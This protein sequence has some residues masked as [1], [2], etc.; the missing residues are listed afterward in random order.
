[1]QQV[2]DED[3]VDVMHTKQK[4]SGEATTNVMCTKKKES[5]EVPVH[6][7]CTR[8]NEIVEARTHVV[9]M[10]KI[11]NE[12]IVAHGLCIE[13]KQI[14]EV[15]L[16]KYDRLTLKWRKENYETTICNVCHFMV[17]FVEKTSKEKKLGLKKLMRSTQMKGLFS[18]PSPT[19]L[20]PQ[21]MRI[22]FIQ[23]WWDPF[24]LLSSRGVVQS[25]FWFSNY[26]NN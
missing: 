12:E 19:H 11:E 16:I 1:M 25:T 10:Q 22:Y 6:V 7:V 2:V 14:E 5:E 23:N 9:H 4:Q 13:K 20:T 24:Y 21:M 15:C 17:F 3:I 18:D 26:S 8:K